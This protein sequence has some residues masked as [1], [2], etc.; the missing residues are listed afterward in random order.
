M[1]CFVALF[2]LISPR[3]ALFVLWI[4]S[5][6]LERAYDDWIVPV[7]GLL[8]AA[9]DDAGLRGLL[10]LGLE[11]RRGLRVVLRDP[12]LPHRP[13]LL[14]PGTARARVG[15]PMQRV[16]FSRNYTLSLSRTCQCFCKYCAFATHQAH[17]H[18]PD[19]VERRLEEAVAAQR[20]GAAGADGRAARGE[21]GGRRAAAL[22]GPRRLHLLRRLGLRARARARHPAPHQPRRALARGPGAAAR[23][24]RLAGADAGVDLA[25]G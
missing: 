8:P 11:R 7:L 25:S 24:D 4:F 14:G 21:P 3:L 16:T 17:I 13:G 5:D 20:Q 9:L 2:A 15:G 6:V 10:V 1:G 22:V 23:G 18:D 19:E 12:R